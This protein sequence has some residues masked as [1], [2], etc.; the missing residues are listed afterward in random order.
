MNG[1]QPGYFS[2]RW[3]GSHPRTA[4]LQAATGDQDQHN[5]Y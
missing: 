4:H 1:C 2:P 5:G 3:I